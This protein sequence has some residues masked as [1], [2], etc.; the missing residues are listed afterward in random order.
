MRDEQPPLDA[1]KLGREKL[2]DHY[3]LPPGL[4]ESLSRS[5]LLIGARGSGKTMYLRRLRHLMKYAFYGDIKKILRPISDDTGAGGL[6]FDSIPPS[7]ELM[8]QHKTVTLLFYWLY[9]Q[10][11]K[12]DLNIPSR[13]IKDL[14]LLLKI[15]Y[16]E[17]HS[18]NLS[19][20]RR[21]INSYENDCFRHGPSIEL[22]VEFVAGLTDAT[23]KSGSNFYLLL[24]RAEEAPYPC[25]NLIFSLLDQS[26]PFFSVVSSR[27][28]IL[29]PTNMLSHDNP[30][31]GDHYDIRHLG[32]HPYCVEWKAFQEA[33]LTSWLPICYRQIPPE[34]LKLLFLI[35]RHSIRTLLELVY[36]SVDEKGYQYNLM[37]NS[38]ERLRG[39]L[40][41]GLQGSLRDLND[42]IK[43]LLN[44]IR[45]NRDK[46]CLPVKIKV[47]GKTQRKFNFLAV[48]Q[49]FHEMTRDEQFV[50]LAL[51]AGL[52]T[53]E[54]GVT[55]HPYIS[56]DSIEV[57]P[58]YIWKEEDTWL[59]TL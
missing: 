3:C 50:R 42:N 45:R 6:T 13:A 1:E 59:I 36:H 27:P 23:E 34:K 48:P 25:L 41:P 10:V 21:S 56:L 58:L 35:S 19:K 12:R 31:P 29:G 52:L 22:F 9:S 28:G 20:I 4:D 49:N 26:N 18:G 39:M 37:I 24:D 33:L 15:E 54:H 38:I 46:P 43:G 8:I 14:F 7:Q 44:K 51:R 2:L 47:P 17:N 40:I 16:T 32:S 57:N 53:T 11:V 55:W 30:I 5:T